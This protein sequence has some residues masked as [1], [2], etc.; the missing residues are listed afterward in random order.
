MVNF[1]A[2]VV[3]AGASVLGAT[4][5][6]NIQ[7]TRSV[8]WCRVLRITPTVFIQPKISSTRFRFRRLTAY[9]G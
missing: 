8:P 7:P 4:A 2:T 3:G 5:N 6:V 1:D 9:P